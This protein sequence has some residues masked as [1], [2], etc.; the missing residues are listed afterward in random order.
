MAEVY[1]DRQRNLLVY[2]APDP[3]TITR[4]VAAAKDLG[5]GY[6]AVPITLANLQLCRWI[7]LPVIPLLNYDYDWPHG[8]QITMPFRAQIITANFLA[9]HPRAFVL[10]DPRTGKTLS[11]LWAAD[12]V[13]RE[14]PRGECRAIIAA[15]LSILQDV[16][17]NTIYQHFLGRRT[18]RI[19]HGSA[20][21]RIKQLAQPADFYI[22][23]HDGVGVGSRVDV[24]GR[25]TLDGFSKLLAERTDIKISIVDEVGGYRAGN[26]RRH[27][28]AR[29][30]LVPRPYFWG[31]TGT[32]TP[33]GPQDAHGQARLVNNAFGESYKS[34]RLRVMY[35]M[36]PFKWV[37]KRGAEAEALK[38]LSPAV[39]F[40]ITDCVDVPP[41]LPP[42]LIN[43]SLS[44]TQK[45]AYSE[46]RKSAMLMVDGGSITAANEAVLRSKLIQVACGAVYE[47]RG[48]D[49][50]VHELNCG[51]RVRAMYDIVEQYR[52]KIIIFA[53]LTSVLS[54]LQKELGKTVEVEGVK[55]PQY[56][57][58]TLN[59]QVPAKERA[60]MLQAFRDPDGLD[61]LLADPGSLQYGVDLSESQIILWFALPEKP[62]Q[63]QQ[64]NE[65]IRG[66][67]QKFPTLVVHLA[68]TPTE[69]EIYKRLEE[70]TSLQGV[71][72]SLVKG[73]NDVIYGRGFNHAPPG[74]AG[75][76]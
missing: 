19:L 75:V 24:K 59:G 4:Y 50:V 72:L 28:V 69:R 13:M 51:P 32:P 45:K 21:E 76:A 58:A 40:K 15:P 52:T 27:R 37:P 62:E 10:S 34:F 9:A 11:L 65:R 66:P 42:Q 46:L 3:A 70:K 5:N 74:F 8:P 1:H 55:K 64:A 36:G 57:V 18:Y 60:G 7:G 35:A 49:R 23:N 68:A 30:V 6:V 2:A 22:I 73:E 16:W 54:L 17:G 53:P 20:Q 14:Y 25:I 31:A 39:R 33:N 44:D 26:T 41:K 61:I 47:Q 56:K 29:L 67:K 38:L 43:V 48:K 63:Y 12:R 71:M